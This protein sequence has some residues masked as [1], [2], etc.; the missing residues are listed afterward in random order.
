MKCTAKRIMAVTSILSGVFTI[1]LIEA[2]MMPPVRTNTYAEGID[3]YFKDIHRVDIRSDN[4]HV[5]NPSDTNL[6]LR[7]NSEQYVD[8]CTHGI[9]YKP[10]NKRENSQQFQ[11]AE[12]YCSGLCERSLCPWVMQWDHDASR[13]PNY[14]KRAQ[15]VSP[16]C[17]Y[18]WL[19]DDTQCEPVRIGM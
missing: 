12:R 13:T 6:V 14:I 7:D 4:N 19:S 9:P 2:R 5:I 17:N 1:I 3:T 8:T 18:T 10:S 11:P 16:S 15:C